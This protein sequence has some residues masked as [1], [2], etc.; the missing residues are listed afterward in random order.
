MKE[1]LLKSVDVIDKN[2]NY[3]I[4]D[5]YFKLPLRVCLFIFLLFMVFSMITILKDKH[6]LTILFMLT[7][8]GSAIL[9]PLISISLSM[10]NIKIDY[11]DYTIK[12]KSILNDSGLTKEDIINN[13]QVIEN[14][15]SDTLVVRIYE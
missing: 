2:V 3:I 8:I 5:K 13:F 4:D 9:G 12:I 6:L 11:I 15:D 7:G 10:E 14:I 1:Q